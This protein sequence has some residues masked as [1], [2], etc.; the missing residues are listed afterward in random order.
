MLAVVAGIVSNSTME[1]DRRYKRSS[2]CCYKNETVG[3]MPVLMTALLLLSISSGNLFNQRS[4]QVPDIA[5]GLVHLVPLKHIT[6][7][8]LG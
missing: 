2:C 5:D 4:A 3:V 1:S 7:F 6:D 8:A